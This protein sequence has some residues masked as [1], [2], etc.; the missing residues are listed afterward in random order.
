MKSRI[1]LTFKIFEDAYVKQYGPC[2]NKKEL[3]KFFN[4]ALSLGLKKNP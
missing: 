2:K 4:M 1:K 3:T